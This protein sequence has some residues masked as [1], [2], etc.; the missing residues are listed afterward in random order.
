MRPRRDPDT[1][2][3]SIGDVDLGFE[4]MLDYVAFTPLQNATGQPAIS[5]PLHQSKSGLPVGVQF[6]ARLGDEG[7]LLALAAQLEQARPWIDRKPPI[8][9]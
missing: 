6:S 5:L 7:T 4:P 1:I 3:T 9:D 2:D 8:W